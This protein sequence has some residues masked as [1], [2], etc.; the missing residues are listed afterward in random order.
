MLFI[1]PMWDNESQ[2]I[3]KQKCT[4]LGYTLHGIAELLGFVGLLL[5]FV[6]GAY[7]AY[8]WHAGTFYSSLLW[9]LVVPFILGIIGEGIYWYSWSLAAKKG[10]HYD[11][12][13]REASWMEDG[14]KRVHKPPEPT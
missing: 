2:R 4:P 5:L 11:Y 13:T 1:Y 6:L 7:L 14:Q 12:E 10:F 9:F 3:G 8:R